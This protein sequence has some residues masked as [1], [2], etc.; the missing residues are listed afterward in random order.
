MQMQDITLSC[1]A[2]VAFITDTDS[3]ILARRHFRSLMA[4]QD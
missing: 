1:Y 2:I 4:G 3:R